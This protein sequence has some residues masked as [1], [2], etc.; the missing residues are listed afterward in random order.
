MQT[1]SITTYRATVQL[2]NTF[3]PLWES[4]AT[5]KILLT[6]EH[7]KQSAQILPEIALVT[8]ISKP[9]KRIEISGEFVD[10]IGGPTEHVFSA[11]C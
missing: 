2:L 10:E 11:L 1:S 3:V 9:E 7:L 5:S 6:G 8:T 4:L